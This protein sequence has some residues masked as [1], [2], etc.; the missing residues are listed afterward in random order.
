MPARAAP[1]DRR[2][3]SS[4]SSSTTA[5]ASASGVARRH[6]H[7]RSPASSTSRYPGMSDATTGSAQPN[8]RASTMPKLSIAERRA[9]RAPSPTASSSVSRSCERRPSTSMPSSGMREAGEQQPD[10]ERV[11]AGDPQAR[12]GAPMDLRPRAEQHRQPLARIVPAGE[13]DRGAR[14]RRDRR[15]AGSATP[16]GITSNGP[17]SQRSAERRACSETAIR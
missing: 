8:A 6:E 10:G 7:G 2:R 1:I 3:G 5:S 16:F 4:S 17:G 9:R 11:G 13:D 14:G 12:A 15:A